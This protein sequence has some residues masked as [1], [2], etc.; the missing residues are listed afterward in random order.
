MTDHETILG[1]LI[2]FDDVFDVLAPEDN[3]ER[4]FKNSE[5][6]SKYRVLKF[7]AIDAIKF[8]AKGARLLSFSPDLIFS[9][10]LEMG[11]REFGGDG[12]D[13]IYYIL[14]RTS[15]DG[16][17]ITKKNYDKLFKDREREAMWVIIATIYMHI[18]PFVEKKNT[19]IE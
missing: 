1:D 14:S 8:W 4:P 12:S 6:L 9:E 18:R 5:A 7:P 15:Q 19:S 2:N 17:M 11:K 13:F 3:T 16:E 10:I